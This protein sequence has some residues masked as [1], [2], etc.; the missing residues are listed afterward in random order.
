[1]VSGWWLWWGQVGWWG[2]IECLVGMVIEWLW[3]NGCGGVVVW[4]SLVEWW[5]AVVEWWGGCGQV[6]VVV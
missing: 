2:V 3:K 1:M 6:A 5:V 4:W